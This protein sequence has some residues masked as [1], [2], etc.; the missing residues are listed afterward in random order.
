MASNQTKNYG[1]NQW[2][3]TDKVVMEDFNADNEKVDAALK[4]LAE[5]AETISRSIPPIVFG[6]YVG[7]GEKTRLISVGFTPRAVLLMNKSGRT[8]YHETYIRTTYGGLAV[9]EGPVTN[10]GY[11]VLSIQPDGFQVSYRVVKPA[12]ITYNI[13]SNLSGVGFCYIAFG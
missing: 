3:R 1:L 7:N 5:R 10:N 12:N 8:T 6:S 4:A 11:D 13:Y 2:E 9:E